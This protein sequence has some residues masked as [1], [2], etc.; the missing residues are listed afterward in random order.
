M[1]EQFNRLDSH[2][3]LDHVA[4]GETPSRDLRDW[5]SFGLEWIAGVIC[6]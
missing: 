4:M 3:I 2:C 6:E 1:G 5:V